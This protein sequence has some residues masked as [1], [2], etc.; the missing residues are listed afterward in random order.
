M[1]ASQEGGVGLA[2]GREVVLFGLGLGM[3]FGSWSGSCKQWR[4][5]RARLLANSLG[6]GK[7]QHQSCRFG[8]EEAEAFIIV[9]PRRRSFIRSA[10]SRGDPLKV[11]RPHRFGF[12]IRT[13][14]GRHR[15][16]HQC[17]SGHEHI[18]CVLR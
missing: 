16:E 18:P 5:G 10:G 7:R 1:S 9:H 6:T 4:T 11:S 14:Q 12:Q 17:G 2:Q 8:G 13:V 15:R 3:G